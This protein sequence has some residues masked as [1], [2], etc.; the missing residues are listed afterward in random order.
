LVERFV[1]GL[2]VKFHSG[3]F[4][5]EEAVF[6]GVFG[7]AVGNF[8]DVL[9]G[10]LEGADVAT[11]LSNGELVLH[12]MTIFVYLRQF[13]LLDSPRNIIP[14]L[15]QILTVP[16]LL[17]AKVLV[18]RVHDISHFFLIVVG[19]ELALL[20]VLS[21]EIEV[22]IRLILPLLNM[23]KIIKHDWSNRLASFNLTLL[24]IVLL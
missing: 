23:Y 24:R 20:A 11:T 6:V 19:V 15:I 12:V 2:I 7:D 4:G 1:L 17:V 18:I 9:A 16:I 10:R 22:R 14:Y 8:F 21:A 3:E 5:G 13:L